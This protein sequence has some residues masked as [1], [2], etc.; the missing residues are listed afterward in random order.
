MNAR[1][2]TLQGIAFPIEQDA[3]DRLHD[4]QAGRVNYVQL[5]RAHRF[6]SVCKMC[7]LVC[8]EAMRVVALF[9]CNRLYH[10][11]LFKL[12]AYVVVNISVAFI[13]LV[14]QTIIQSSKLQLQ[15]CAQHTICAA[16][17]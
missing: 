2:Q 10:T 15:P 8:F 3:I 9:T 5:V 16:Q 17:V 6:N 12:C 14:K 13:N 1:Q 7:T 4:I 11:M